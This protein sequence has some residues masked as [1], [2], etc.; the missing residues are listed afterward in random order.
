MIGDLYR[1][2]TCHW[3]GICLYVPKV[4]IISPTSVENRGNVNFISLS[5]LQSGVGF[6]FSLADIGKCYDPIRTG[7]KNNLETF[8]LDRRI[9]IVNS[10]FIIITVEYLHNL[11]V[12]IDKNQ[13]PV[14][15]LFI[16]SNGI[17]RGAV[18]TRQAIR[19]S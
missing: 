12:T 2:V 15:Y 9:R 14:F 18:G 16:V 4:Q 5:K 1:T 13:P 11:A 3:N 6:K 8:F 19:Q 17:G 7:G 10:G